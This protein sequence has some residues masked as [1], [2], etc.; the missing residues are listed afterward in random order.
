MNST[1]SARV[2]AMI[3]AAGRSRRMGQPK[4]LLEY[5]GRPLLVRVVDAALKSD[6]T[7][8]T[9]VVHADIGRALG[10]QLKTPEQKRLHIL[11]NPAPHSEMIDSVRIAL[12]ALRERHAARPADGFLVSPGDLPDLTAADFN[13]CIDAFREAPD[14]IVIAS[15]NGRRGHPLIF[16]AT[17]AEYVLSPAC[18]QGLHAL[19]REHDSIVRLVERPTPSVTRD[20]NTTHD[21]ENRE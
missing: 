4:Q 5:D 12:R 8:V 21:L 20:A 19:P 2:C 17:L 1:S 3:P 11:E 10:V 15:H 13:A 16:P 14:R 9:V 7:D 6:V 18:D